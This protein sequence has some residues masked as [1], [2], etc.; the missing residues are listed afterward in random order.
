MAR[1]SGDFH[2]ARSNAIE[3]AKT[4]LPLMAF[5]V[6]NDYVPT[7]TKHVK[8]SSLRSEQK[9]VNRTKVSKYAQTPAEEF[10]AIKVWKDS[11][12]MRV[13]EGNHRVNAALQR[14]ETH[15]K[16]DIHTNPYK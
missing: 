10:P 5:S 4:E 14:G 6:A 12:G 9:S 2:G 8:I 1:N 11:R 7:E 3:P 15:I 16:A 13:I